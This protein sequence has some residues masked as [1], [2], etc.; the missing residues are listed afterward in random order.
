MLH[1]Q[2]ELSQD[3]WLKQG[4]LPAGGSSSVV[5]VVAVIHRHGHPAE[6]LDVGGKV[7]WMFGC[8]G[9]WM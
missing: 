7:G 9:C 1:G 4:E 8:F 2:L 5:V 6:H 3:C